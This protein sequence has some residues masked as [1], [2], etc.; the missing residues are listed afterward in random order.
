MVSSGNPFSVGSSSLLVAAD[1]QIEQLCRVVVRWKAPARFGGFAN[2]A[3]QAFGDKLAT[4]PTAVVQ[5]MAHQ[6][7]DADLDGGIGESSV[8]GVREALQAINNGE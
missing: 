2:D 3:V 8:D 5:G 6:T 1:C 7:R 4:L